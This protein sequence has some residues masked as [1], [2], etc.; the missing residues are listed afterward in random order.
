MSVAEIPS[1][2]QVERPSLPGG[3]ALWLRQVGALLRLE[4]R[5]NLFGRYSLAV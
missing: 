1:P 5:K 2:R 4:L 3:R